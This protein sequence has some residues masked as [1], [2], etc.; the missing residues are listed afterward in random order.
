MASLNFDISVVDEF[1]L[2]STSRHTSV[3]M[4]FFM[5]IYFSPHTML[6]AKLNN[7]KRRHSMLS[8][9]RIYSRLAWW[10]ISKARNIIP[11]PLIDEHPWFAHPLLEPTD[12]FLQRQSIM[13]TRSRKPRNANELGYKIEKLC[14]ANYYQKFFHPAVRGRTHR[15][16][17]C[18]RF[19]VFCSYHLHQ[20]VT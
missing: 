18:D 2:V 8:I 7:S 1:I 6:T 12:E 15:E 14:Q 11:T 16:S 9:G 4:I 19:S 5:T 13:T 3:Q 17:S 10:L 20:S